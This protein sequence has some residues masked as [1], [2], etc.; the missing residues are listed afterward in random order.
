MKKVCRFAAGSVEFMKKTQ[1]DIHVPGHCTLIAA[2]A[3]QPAE[4]SQPH[5][6]SLLPTS[7]HPRQLSHPKRYNAASLNE[8]SCLMS[9]SGPTASF[10]SEKEQRSQARKRRLPQRCSRR[11]RHA[12][13]AVER[14]SCNL[15][16]SNSRLRTARVGSGQ[17]AVGIGHCSVNRV[18]TG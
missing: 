13:A 6:H 14:C 7:P 16:T 1:A 9:R 5:P 2:S 3:Q 11:S 4:H 12:A 17:W 18:V 15:W 10:L 8:A